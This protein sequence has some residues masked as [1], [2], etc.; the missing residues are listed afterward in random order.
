[1]DIPTLPFADT[2]QFNPTDAA[3]TIVQDGDSLPPSTFTTTLSPSLLSDLRR[4]ADEPGGAELLPVLAASVRHA[5]PL[6][7]H[8]QHGRSMVRLS[9]F[10][11]DQLF[12]CPL[13]LCALSHAELAR[14]HLVHVEPEGL[15]APFAPDG[16][17]CST[18]EFGA[19]A[20]LLWQLS[21][22]GAR[23]ELLPEIAGTVRY[24]LAPGASVRGLPVDKCDMAL[25][26]RLLGGPASLDELAGWSV[27]EPARVRRLLNA[28]YLQSG[29]IISR[30]FMAPERDAPAARRRAD[31]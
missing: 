24:R 11:R 26:Q 9:V 8:L 16:S 21:L 22:H 15:L 20:P 5:R 1:M 30:A 10:P 29:L 12:H 25:L 17:P 27:L 4:F 28:L 7:L 18:L 14:L 31:A 3:S 19:M 2:T 13:N 23:S 6:A